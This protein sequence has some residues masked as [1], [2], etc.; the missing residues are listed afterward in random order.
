MMRRRMSKSADISEI[1]R[2][3]SALDDGVD[4]D[5][6]SLKK[7]LHSKMPTSTD[8]SAASFRRH[9]RKDLTHLL[10]FR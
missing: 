7:P 9:M 10:A 3:F 4:S 6:I 5:S 8:I 1:G 2:G